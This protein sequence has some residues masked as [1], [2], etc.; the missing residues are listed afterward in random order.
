MNEGP[1]LSL[2]PPKQPL[3][4]R[5]CS[6]QEASETTGLGVWKIYTLIRDGRLKSIK[7]DGRRLILRLLRGGAVTRTNSGRTH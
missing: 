6:V 7:I 2:R 1:A 4:R 5:A 3:K